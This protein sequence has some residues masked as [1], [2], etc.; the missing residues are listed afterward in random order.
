MTW[1]LVQSCDD[2]CQY[3]KATLCSGQDDTDAPIVYVHSDNLPESGTV[4]FRVAGLC[5][6]ISATASLGMIEPEDAYLIKANLDGNNFA[7]CAACVSDG[8]DDDNSGGYGIDYHDAGIGGGGGGFGTWGAGY[9]GGGGGSSGGG[10]GGTPYQP[11]FKLATLCGGQSG[12]PSRPP[13]YVENW[14]SHSV[15]LIFRY[16]G[17]CYSFNPGGGGGTAKEDLPETRITLRVTSGFFQSCADC[18]AGKKVELCSGQ[19]ELWGYDALNKDVYVP[20]QAKMPGSGVFSMDGFCWH[21]DATQGYSTIPYGAK[22]LTNISKE[23]PDCADCGVGVKVTPCPEQ[24]NLDSAP[25][26]WVRQEYL[27]TEEGTSYYFRYAAWC[28]EIP[29]QEAPGIIPP[30]AFEVEPANLYEDCADCICGVPDPEY[31]YRSYSCEGSFRETWWIKQDDMDAFF[32]DSRSRWSAIFCKDPN[33]FCVV[34]YPLSEPEIIPVGAG[35]MHFPS[36]VYSSCADCFGWNWDP[37]PKPPPGPDDPDP[38]PE[39]DP[40]EPP[41]PEPD[42]PDDPDDP[43]PDPDPPPEPTPDPDDEDPID[44]DDPDPDPNPEPT[45]DPPTPNPPP[46]PP[47]K[48]WEPPDPDPPAPVKFVKAYRCDTGAYYGWSKDGFYTPGQVVKISDT[49]CVIIGGKVNS[50]PKGSPINGSVV[51]SCAECEVDWYRLNY[52]ACSGGDCY[53]T[54]YSESF[55]I[56]GAAPEGIVRVSGIDGCGSLES[57]E[58]EGSSTEPKTVTS[59]TDCCECYGCE[60]RIMAG[61]GSPCPPG[62]TFA[63]CYKASSTA[64]VTITLGNGCSGQISGTLSNPCDDP[65]SLNPYYQWYGTISGSGTCDGSPWTASMEVGLRVEGNGSCDSVDFILCGAIP[66]PADGCETPLLPE[67]NENNYCYDNGDY[68]TGFCGEYGGGDCDGGS[69]DVGNG[70]WTLDIQISGTECD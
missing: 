17:A 20:K 24:P 12:V 31:G 26:L 70:S 54:G 37:T 32:A 27:P 28:Y 10:G 49:V 23:Y 46:V 42:D 57:T 66:D 41:E 47:P 30:Y 33:N 1:W 68:C 7:S 8:D 44:P 40:P 63:C 56:E 43:P 62:E 15:D 69:W 9:F 61:P 60:A 6:S 4:Y 36:V 59:M 67:L 14:W 52:D 21:Y 25:V 2:C 64:T 53:M 48:P 22:L 34:F 19:T 45:P 65:C 55:T 13:I 5:Y 50:Q 16:M 18:Q 38:P 51:D 11:P 58:I 3:A 39:P 29:Y 35:V